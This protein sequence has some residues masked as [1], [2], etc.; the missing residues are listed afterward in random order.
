MK[1]V[2]FHTVTTAG[3][4]DFFQRTRPDA[5]LDISGDLLNT[6]DDSVKCGGIRDIISPQLTRLIAGEKLPVQSDFIQLFRERCRRA[7]QLNASFVTADF[8]PLACCNDED[9]EK[10]L[11]EFISGLLGILHQYKLT[12]LFTVRLPMTGEDDMVKIKKFRHK[13]LYPGLGFAFDFH[14]HEPGAFDCC[15]IPDIFPFDCGNWQISFEP[16][17]GNFL[18]RQLIDKFFTISETPYL[19]SARISVNIGKIQ[20]D[21]MMIQDIDGLFIQSGENNQ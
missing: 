16:E 11:L 9:K 8:D 5:V 20:P 4:L 6:A 18:T 15:R 10:K 2:F 13:L 17:K 3:Q 19:P 7:A 14:P 21:V 12:L 1:K